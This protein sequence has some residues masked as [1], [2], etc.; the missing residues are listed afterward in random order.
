MKIEM[1]RVDDAFHFEGTGS[2]SIKVHT[3]GSPEIGGQNAGVR[4][5]ELLLMGLASCSAIDVVLIL[6][7]QRQEITDFRIVADGDRT[8]EEGTKRSPFRTI[9]LTFRLKGV[10]LDESKINRAINLSMEKYC[11]ATAQLEALATITHSVEIID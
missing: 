1:V 4:P 10:D 2:S 6:K 11:S 9:H 3:D 8:E 5:M 7:K